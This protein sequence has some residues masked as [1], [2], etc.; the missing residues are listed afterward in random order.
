LPTHQP[1]RQN[2]TVTDYKHTLNLPNT[3][4]PMR[5]NLASREPERLRHWQETDVHGQLR[6][7][8][9]G[10]GRYILHDGPP[11]ANGDLHIGHAV[12][13]V[14]KDIIVKSRSLEGDD[15]V[16]VPGWDCHG[17]P[18]ELKVEQELG[19]SGA[20]I[21][22]R[23]FRAACRAYASRQID[24]QRRDFQ[25]MGVMGDWDAPY[26]TMNPQTEANILRALGRIYARGHVTRGFKPVHWCCDCG[27]ALAEAEVE[28][29]DHRSP[30][31]DVRFPVVDAAAL[32]ERFALDPASLGGL[33][34]SV[35]IWTTTPWTLPANQAVALHPA[36]VYALVAVTGDEQGPELLILAEEL[37]EPALARYGLVQR[38]LLASVPGAAL[39]GLVLRHPYLEREVPVILGAHVTTEAGTGAVHT[40]PG[41]GQDDYLVGLDYGLAVDNPVDGRGCFLPGTPLVAGQFTAQANQTLIAALAERGQLLA[42][43][44]HRHSY[45]HCWRHKT[46]ILFR[47]TPQWFISMDAA[48]LRTQ[49]LAAI[50][51]VRFVP[52]WG[53]A[54]I[55]GMVRNRPDWCISRQRLWGVPIAFLVHKRSG[56]PHPR[57]LEVLEQVALRMER[58]GIDAW[59]AISVEELI[60]DEAADYEK[61]TDILDVWFDSGSTHAAVLE[62]DPRLQKP[63]DLYLEGSDQHRGWFQSSLLTG[64]AMDGVAPYKG[65][66]THGFTVDEHGRKMSK[67]IGN[68]IAPQDVMNR[69]GADV[70]RLWVA[71]SDYSGEIAVSDDILQRT[72]DSYR[73]IRNTARFL[74][75]NLN[76]FDP[77]TDALPLEALLPFDRWALDRALA[78]QSEIR[79]AYLAYEFHHVQHRIHHFCAFD[80]GALYL[81]V[82][83]DRQYTTRADSRARRSCQTAMYHIVEALA[84]WIAPILSYTADELW[85]HIPGARDPSVL[86]AEW[87]PGLV[88]LDGADGRDHAFW[89]RVVAVRDGV[90]K[91]LEKARVAG[92]IKGSLQAEVVL[93]ASPALCRT[94]ALLDDELH[95]VL[96][97]SAA[98]CRVA[99][100]AS[101]PPGEATT[102]PDGEVL[103][104]EVSASTHAKCPRCWHHRADVGADPAHPTL[105]GRCVDNVA[106]DGESRQV[107]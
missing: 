22:P 84:R 58:E 50:A 39:E 24:G 57:T 72:A 82:I 70:M 100:A 16:Y 87:Y 3:A 104:V 4:F 36:I 92:V 102:L 88:A 10:R 75:A 79:E 9:A 15:A 2:L 27:S 60:G 91:A 40:A 93:H 107:V 41:H 32:A 53:R 65:V 56:E 37:I 67:S 61:V 98:H 18:I 5:A 63:A 45:P 25:R 51:E 14:I 43:V 47:A 55:D 106:G 64:V 52:E 7:A 1:A 28:Y 29:Q 35:P 26:L 31:I 71:A 97:T 11:Y 44:D 46:P 34:A 78:T 105:C 96:I 68:I 23:A 62:C 6:R 86:L 13:K 21:S 101:V 83:K 48:G 30:A 54:R 17:L 95:F 19:K 89:E 103:W 33:A 38:A 85:E 76:G 12:N 8:R 99:E 20:L 90:S 77:A 94:L 66:L 69:L 49:A 80:M 59:D 73:R 81:D 74:L 42:H